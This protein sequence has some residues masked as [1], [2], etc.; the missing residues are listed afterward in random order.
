MGHEISVI[1]PTYNSAAYLPEAIES[2]LN[3]TVP[4]LEVIVVDDGSTDQTA[5]ILEHYSGRIVLITQE[6]RGLSAARNRGIE[7]ARGI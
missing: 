3:Q 4:P 6:N 5:Q 1:I 2:A 7:E